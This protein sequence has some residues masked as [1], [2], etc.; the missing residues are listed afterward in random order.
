MD[1]NPLPVRFG[2]PARLSPA[3]DRPRQQPSDRRGPDA[4]CR[5]DLAIREPLRTQ[6][7][8]KPITRRQ[9]VCNQTH[10]AKPSVFVG[11]GRRRHDAIVRCRPRDPS[12]TPSLAIA[13]GV[14][15]DGE[16]PAPQVR[17]TPADLQMVQE[18]EEG[19][20]QHVLGVVVLV[21]QGQCEAVHRR[22]VLLE[23]LLDDPRCLVRSP[24]GLHLA[25]TGITHR[26]P[27]CDKTCFGTV[28]PAGLPG[29]SLSRGPGN[30]EA[31]SPLVSFP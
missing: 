29:V 21:E 28:C 9:S 15:R 1:V 27:V 31:A 12:S 16:N 6:R 18:L 2:V 5:S 4:C 3:I 22:P 19:F 30:L 23:Q 13:R 11:E 17:G 7:Q 8:E 26:G 10:D 20:L 14:C 24:G 25:A